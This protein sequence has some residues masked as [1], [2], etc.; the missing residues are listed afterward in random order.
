MHRE[1]GW[2]IVGGVQVHVNNKHLSCLINGRVPTKGRNY[3]RTRNLRIDRL[4]DFLNIV[5]R[6]IGNISAIQWWRPLVTSDQF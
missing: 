3:V 5:L 4:V 1:A 6:R 2:W